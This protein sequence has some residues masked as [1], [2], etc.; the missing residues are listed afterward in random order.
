[1]SDFTLGTMIRAL[2]SDNDVESQYRGIIEQAYAVSSAGTKPWMLTMK[3]KE[4]IVCVFN[5]MY[6][7]F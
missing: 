3:D 4:H 7:T 5:S 6:A 2:Y 1:M